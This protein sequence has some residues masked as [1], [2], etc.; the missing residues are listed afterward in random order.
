VSIYA[1]IAIASA[2]LAVLAGTWDAYRLRRE[3]R[4]SVPVMAITAGGPILSLWLYLTLTGLALKVPA[5][6]A[7][8]GAGAIIG[9]VAARRAALTTVADGGRIRLVGASWLPLPAAVSVAAVQVSGAAESL[10]AQIVSLAALE[11][12]VAF[13]VASAITLVY[14]RAF[15]AQPLAPPVQPPARPPA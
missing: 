4:Y 7:L 13:G 15:A 8:F 11:A 3:Q 9:V 2:T 14:R 12:A 1:A 10:S 5:S 6:A